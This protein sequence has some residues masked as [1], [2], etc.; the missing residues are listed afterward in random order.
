MSLDTSLPK[1]FKLLSYDEIDSTSEEAKRLA[2]KGAPEGIVV[3]SKNKLLGLEGED[4]NGSQ[5]MEIFF[6]Q[7]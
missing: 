7:F 3:W 2:K 1:P 5:W 6:A 4:E